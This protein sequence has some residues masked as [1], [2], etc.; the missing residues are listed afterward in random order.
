MVSKQVFTMNEA[1]GSTRIYKPG[2]WRVWRDRL[3]EEQRKK[4]EL[5]NT[6][7]DIEWEPKHIWRSIWRYWFGGVDEDSRSHFGKL[8][9]IIYYSDLLDDA[10]NK[11]LSIFLFKAKVALHIST[12][13]DQHKKIF[14]FK[15]DGHDFHA[16]SIS[17]KPFKIT[18]FSYDE[19][20]P[21]CG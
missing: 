10:N 4:R 19:N 18:A 7:R 2:D 17:I 11:L 8:I 15:A 20:T 9:T 16:L 5:E 12:I 1:R 13:K 3:Y 6:L 21:N 14:T